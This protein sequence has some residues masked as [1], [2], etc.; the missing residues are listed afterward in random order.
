M[1]P[2]SVYDD[3]HH[4]HHHHHESIRDL[5]RDPTRDVSRELSRPSSTADEGKVIFEENDTA[6]ETCG[7]PKKAAPNVNDSDFGAEE[8]AAWRKI[9]E[10]AMKKQEENKEGAF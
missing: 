8:K 6:S 9:Y 2:A 7:G 4:H 1:P 3:H 5:S 10:E